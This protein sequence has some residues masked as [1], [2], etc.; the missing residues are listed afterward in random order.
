MFNSISWQEFF[1][2][3]A[4][5]IGGYYFITTLLLYSGEITNIFKQ[6][7]PDLTKEKIQRHQ[8][9]SNESID[10][11]GAVRYE[12]PRELNVPREEQISSE[13]ISPLPSTVPEEAIE[14][15][16]GTSPE[17]ILALSVNEVKDGI[18]AIATSDPDCTK[19]DFITLLQ[20]LLSHYSQ[21]R[22]TIYRADIHEFIM[23]SCRNNFV[24]EIQPNEIIS[25][26]SSSD[27]DQ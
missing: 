21:L 1:Y 6:K 10:L 4:F 25:L 22:D 17:E 11:M 20:T 9:R 27:Q 16:K 15:A 13:E 2:A 3:A 14:V 8:T 12:A 24:F 5:V 23:E 7:K 19:E 18:K 26:W